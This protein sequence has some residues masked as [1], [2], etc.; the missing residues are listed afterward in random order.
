MTI[1]HIQI[2][3]V[4][5][6]LIG[7]EELHRE[8]DKFIKDDRHALIL[9]VNINCLNLANEK[10]WLKTFLNNSEIVFCD[11]SGV[12]LGAKLLGETIHERV[13]YADWMWYLADF[14]NENNYSLYLLG[15]KP[16]IA[17]I[18]SKKLIDKFPDLRIVGTHHGYFDKSN[19]SIENVKVI[20][21]INELSPNILI[22]GFGMPTQEQWL[23]ENWDGLNADIALTGGAVFDYVSGELRRAPDWMTNHGME[24]LGRMLIEP[25]RLWRRYLIGIPI[26]FWRII[27]QRLG[28]LKI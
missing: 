1:D 25:R 22:L 24:W 17:E 13:T 2:F 14:A 7:M 3:G 9:N 27:L 18:A 15:G 19:G 8:I 26:F 20:E 12:I 6:H 11:G 28:L 5:V 21:G 4:N 16:G 23:M 10:L